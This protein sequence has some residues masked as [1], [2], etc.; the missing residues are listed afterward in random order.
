MRPLRAAST[1]ANAK[2]VVQGAY[3]GD[4]RQHERIHRTNMLR[5]VWVHS[6]SFGAV[7]RRN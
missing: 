2:L 5:L 3:V 4:V 1:A 7:S 6:G